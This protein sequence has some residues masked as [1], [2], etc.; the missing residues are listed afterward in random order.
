M[1]NSR[2][3][4]KFNIF[5]HLDKNVKCYCCFFFKFYLS[6]DKQ[7]YKYAIIRFNT[8]NT[9]VKRGCVVLDILHFATML[10]QIDS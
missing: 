7:N 9:V 4:A 1:K 8:V 10:E 6:T 2:T 5:L 3:Y